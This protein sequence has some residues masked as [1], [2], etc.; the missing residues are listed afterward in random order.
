M[1]LI[2]FLYICNLNKKIVFICFILVFFK[3]FKDWNKLTVNE[4]I[5]YSFLVNY[6][7]M[8][9]HESWDKENER[10]YGEKKL[11]MDIIKEYIDKFS[12][13]EFRKITNKKFLK[14]PAYLCVRFRQF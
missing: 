12:S 8:H 5:V 9:Q 7:T 10:E 14:R 2:D 11:N 3:E 1:Y 4:K 13:L 6:A